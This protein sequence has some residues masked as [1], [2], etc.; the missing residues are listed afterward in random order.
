MKLKSLT[1]T[2]LIMKIPSIEEAEA[3]DRHGLGHE[4]T[5]H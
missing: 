2:F 4:Y 5:V 3:L 1:Y